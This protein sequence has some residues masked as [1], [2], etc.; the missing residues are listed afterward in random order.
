MKLLNYQ[1]Y[2]NRQ[3]ESLTTDLQGVATESNTSNFSESILSVNTT[4]VSSEATGLS[5]QASVSQPGRTSRTHT[6]PSR[7]QID[8]NSKSYALVAIMFLVQLG[9]HQLDTEVCVFV[10]QKTIVAVYVDDIV[11]SSDSLKINFVLDVKASLKTSDIPLQPNL[12]LTTE[13]V[14][15]SDE[16]LKP[17]DITLYQQATGKL[18]YLKSCTRPGL[19]FPVSLLS[20]FSLCPKEKHWGCKSSQPICLLRQCA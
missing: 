9:F 1:V 18:M 3:M 17:I 11:I 12:G 14:D 7:L 15:E 5:N 6:Q 19:A 20:R 16:L 2:L 10:S 8:Q 13:L 4:E